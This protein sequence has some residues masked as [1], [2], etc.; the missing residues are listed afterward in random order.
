MKKQKRWIFILAMM[1][2]LSIS[3]SGC[4]QSASTKPAAEESKTNT[5]ESQKGMR[6]VT[7]MVGREIQIPEK[8][9]KVGYNANQ[10]T[11]LTVLGAEDLTSVAGAG[12]FDFFKRFD[13]RFED[14]KFTT[15]EEDPPD[16]EIVLSAA[17]DVFF[18]RATTPDDERIAPLE[19]AGIP[20]YVE[21]G[22][23]EDSIVPHVRAMAEALGEQKYKDAAE[24]YAEYYNGV[25]DDIAERT[26]DI[27]EE[28]KPTVLMFWPR[29]DGTYG[30][31]SA[32]HI[33]GQS[34]TIAGG[35]VVGDFD[36]PTDVNVEQVLEWN[37]D[38]IIVMDTKDVYDE[39]I[40]RPELQNLSAIQ[41]GRV[42][43]Q[44]THIQ[45]PYTEE[46]PVFQRW[47]AKVLYPEIFTDVDFKADIK[48][49]ATDYYHMELPDSFLDDM[50]QG[51]A[52]PFKK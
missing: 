4:G 3:M 17:P 25:K 18:L 30:A 43:C 34:V 5:D 21:Y 12:A 20:V 7:D 51:V 48:A 31:T 35:K 2:V 9:T 11:T 8:I 41:N 36:A 50:E 32:Q 24:K 26:K 29:E 22:H 33:T 6:T 46:F 23:T 39:V 49:F 47:V 44:P 27:P 52:I 37:P 45:M 28:D 1:L 16:T 14:L 42:Y 13:D 40:A 15:F 10:F 38:V 19:E